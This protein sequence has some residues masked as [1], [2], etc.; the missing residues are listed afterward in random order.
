VDKVTTYAALGI[1]IAGVITLGGA[2]LL[3]T[4]ESK[5]TRKQ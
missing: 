1:G 5:K 2:A 4:R 3:G